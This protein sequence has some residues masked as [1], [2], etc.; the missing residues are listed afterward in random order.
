MTNIKYF[1]YNKYK[2]K[3]CKC[4]QNHIHDSRGEARY[5][6]ELALMKAAC[7]IKNYTIQQTIPLIVNGKTITRH[8]VD[9][10]VIT[11]TGEKEI[12]E[13]KGFETEIWKMKYKLFQAIYPD[14]PYIVVRGVY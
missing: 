9:F 3:S 5:C 10:V 8:R 1:R 6:D 12:H 14:I 2:N 7:E 4:N 11:N 13:Y